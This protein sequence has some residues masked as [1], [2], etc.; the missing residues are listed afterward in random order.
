MSADAIPGA[1]SSSVQLMTDFCTS[2]FSASYQ[3]VPD[4]Y[5]GEPALSVCRTAAASNHG[6]GH[7]GHAVG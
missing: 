5:Y 1:Y 2:K 3:E 4:P 7:A 6:S